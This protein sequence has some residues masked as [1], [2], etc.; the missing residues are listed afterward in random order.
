MTSGGAEALKAAIRRS[1]FLIVLLVLLGIVSVN[2]FKQLRG[3]SYTSSAQVLISTTPIWQIITQTVPPFIDPT[4]TLDTA[5]ALAGSP[6]VY[7][8]AAERVGG[9]L[10]TPSELQSATSVSG[11][12]NNDILTFSAKSTTPERAVAI[13]NAVAHGYIDWRGQLESQAVR[14]TAEELRTRL[15][16]LGA[17]DPARKDLES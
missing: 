7:E 12:T 8:R 1:L 9:S 15:K 6:M 5:Q 16:T 4:R 2:A 14:Q 11:G 17:N 3:P 10:G 13:A